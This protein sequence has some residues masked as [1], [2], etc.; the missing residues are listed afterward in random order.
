MG[1][2]KLGVLGCGNMGSAILRGIIETETLKP[3]EIIV[4]DVVDEILDSMK[5]EYDVAVA[6]D[7]VDLCASS[8][9][10]LFA[11]KPQY[12][13]DVLN[14]I[15][16]SDTLDIEKN[17]IVS[18]AAGQSID[19]YQETLGKVPLVRIMP[20]ILALIGQAAS[21]LCASE[22]VDGS[23]FKFVRELF[24]AVGETVV[25]DE[26]LMD[27]VTGLSGSGP[28][29]VSIFVE[30]LADGAV[31]MGLPRKTA[32]KLAAQTVAGTGAMIVEKDIHPAVMKDMVSSPG[33]TTI[34]GL[35]MLESLGFRRAAM[36]AVISATEKSKELGKKG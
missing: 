29:F 11:I 2:Y 5:A 35:H 6:S 8:D 30:A 19:K 4:Y 21:A 3:K 31:K 22:E 1:T 23:Q 7:E 32:Y 13:Q 36:D 12:L 10:I 26:K 9:Y 14:K 18:I 16:S 20:N 15:S 28:A 25:V 24:E 27:V 34:T 17:V 33:G